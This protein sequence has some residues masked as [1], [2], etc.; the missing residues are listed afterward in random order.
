MSPEA[1]STSPERGKPNVSAKR[2]YARLLVFGILLIAIAIVV[3]AMLLPWAHERKLR[4]L[5]EE[6]LA[7][8]VHD[9]PR[10]ALTF[11]YYGS[12]LLKSGKLTES[13]AAFK[14]ATELDPR[15]ARAYDGLGS[16]QMR[17]GKGKSANEAFAEAARRDPK[18]AAAYLGLSETFYQ[19]GSARRAI[20]PLKKLVELEPKNSVAWY[21]LGKLY[22][23]DHQADQ[24]YAALHRAVALDAKNPDYW[25]DLAHI[26][27]HYG[28]NEE[29]ETELRRAIHF[30]PNDPVAHLWLGELYA[31]M[32]DTPRLFGQAE[33]E[34]MAAVARDPSMA[35]GF[36]EIGEL[37]ERHQNYPLA[38]ANYR[39]AVSLD[40][41]DDVPLRQ[42]GECEVRIGNKADGEAKIRAAE[43]MAAAKKEITDL[44]NRSLADPQNPELHLRLAR[45]WRKYDNDDDAI[46]EYHAYTML[47]PPDP[48][49]EKEIEA[50]VRAA[51]KSR[52]AASAGAH[53]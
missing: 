43:Q 34:L 11:L 10:D 6:E 12:A 27:I 21:H 46:K 17:L 5:S 49:V 52:T 40:N 45:M 8:A 48:A 3:R 20:E 9:D 51:Q 44:Q 23:E 50:Y 19:A 13:E 39:K 53:R 2:G 14:R 38:I 25:R 4:A 26:S 33:Q 29:A 24:A 31:R 32:G 36:T 22:G 15:L 37:Y 41:T 1:P 30:A 35:D 47:G 42:L 16:V 18:D 28:K 7:Y